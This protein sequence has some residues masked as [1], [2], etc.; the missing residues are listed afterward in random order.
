MT[1]SIEENT[2]QPHPTRMVYNS[3]QLSPSVMETVSLFL[4]KKNTLTLFLTL[5]LALLLFGW[6]VMGCSNSSQVSLFI[7]EGCDFL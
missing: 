6:D 7:G 4:S 3:S 5:T 1:L 2:S